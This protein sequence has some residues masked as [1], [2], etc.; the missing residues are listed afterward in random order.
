MQNAIY[1]LKGKYRFL[2]NFYDNN[3]P[4]RVQLG[5]KAFFMPTVEHA[6]QASNQPDEWFWYMVSSAADPVR[7]KRLGHLAC[8]RPDWEEVKISVMWELL[9]MKFS[10]P[11]LKEMLVATGQAEIYECNDWG[12]RFWGCDRQLRGENQLGR[13]LVQLRERLQAETPMEA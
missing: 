7:A 9:T 1:F 2:S 4:L 8:L 13:L 10:Y 5:D 3:P 12:D 6:Y 11:P